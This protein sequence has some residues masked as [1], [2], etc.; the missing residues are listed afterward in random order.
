MAFTQA[1]LDNIAASALED[2]IDKGTVWKQNI[3]NKPMLQAFNDASGSFTGGKDNVNFGV[4]SGQGGGTLKGYNTDDS[5]TY[6]N[7]TGTIRAAFPW[8]EHHIGIVVTQTELKIDGIDV[9]ETN[10][11]QTTREISG[12]EDHALAN[13]LDEKVAALGE[14]YAVSLDSLIHGDGTADAKA[15][16]GIRSLVLD[17]PAVGTTGT[18]N[19]ATYAWWRNRAATTAAGGAGGQAPIASNVADGGALIT[20]LETEYRQLGRYKSG[21]P[22]WKMFCGSAFMDAYLKEL[23]ANGNYTMTGWQGQTPDGGMGNPKFKGIDMVYDPT[24]DTLN[25]SKRCY[26]LDLGRTG[27]KLLY[28]DGNDMK[29]HNP[30]R[31]YDKYVMYQGITTTAVL[32]AKQ[33]NS[34]G[35][36]DIA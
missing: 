36:Y 26:W 28:L 13:L 1:E 25:L 9:V 12:R 23:R 14:D 3:Q 30:A 10:A 22:N 17:N 20:F 27:L 31:P 8:K 24:L 21:T 4:A 2:Y 35:V 7:P 5:V 11:K 33:L 19:R 6:Y 29:K 15:I 34:S 32:I 16:A 18:I